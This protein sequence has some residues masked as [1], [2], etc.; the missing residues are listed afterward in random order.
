MQPKFKISFSR[1]NFSQEETD[2]V[3]KVMESDWPSQ[4]QIT[5]EFEALLS[6]YL[7]S[8]AIVVNNGSSG[9]MAALIAHGI[10]PGDKVVV[11]AFTF[12]ATA[13]IPKLLGAEILVADIDPHTFNITPEAVEE[14]VK[15]NKIKAVI[16][17]DIAGLPVD[18]DAFVE[19]SK[20]YNFILIEDAAQSFGAEYKNKKVGSFN[21]T[22]IFSFQ[23]TKHIATI[24]GGCIATLDD[25]IIKKISQIKDYGRNKIDRY[26]SDVVAANFRT[27]DLQSAIGIAQFRKVE[28]HILQRNRIANE[29]KNKIDG[30]DF[31]NIPKYVTRHAYMFFL[32]STKN[33]ETRDKY[34]NKMSELGVETRKLWTPVHM[35]PCNP[36]LKGQKCINTEQVFNR[37]FSI[38]IYNSLT[39]DDTKLVIDTFKRV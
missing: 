14:I 7:S 20:K 5:E 26:V 4:G 30:F 21:H 17:V 15:R 37:T 19:L 36:E 12:I 3:L 35:Q 33:K 9:L 27:T 1:P 39:M 38:P 2:A 23:I 31:Q 25:D 32:L 10:K 11:P 34:I 28:S 8:N 18:I 16:V 22:A 13:S 24:E 29:Y 6:K